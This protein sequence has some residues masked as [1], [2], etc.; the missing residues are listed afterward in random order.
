MSL[1]PHCKDNQLH[2]LKFTIS[3]IEDGGFSII[4]YFV[5]QTGIEVLTVSN[6]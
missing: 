4:W 5:K 1:S 3:K 2:L 6:Q